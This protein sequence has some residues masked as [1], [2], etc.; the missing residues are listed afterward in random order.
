MIIRSYRLYEKNIAVLKDYGGLRSRIT[1]FK[2]LR[3]AGLEI[4]RKQKFRGQQHDHK[5]RNNISRANSK[6]FEYA[7]CNPWD[8][9]VTLTIDGSKYQRDDLGTYYK[10]FSQWL[11]D[12]KK[13]YNLDF[14]YV[15][16]PELHKDGKSWHMHGLLHGLPLEHLT[17]NDNGYLD[18]EPYRRKFGYISIDRIRDQ[19][20]TA[21]YITKYISKDLSKC[22]TECNAKMYY[23]SRGLKT[24]TEVLR[25]TLIDGIVPDFENEYL[26]LQWFDRNIDINTLKSKF[27]DNSKAES[28]KGYLIDL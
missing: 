13:K 22:I 1:V 18:W 19:A 23:C 11:R 25:G 10:A 26:K 2:A 5:L 15:L 12:Y 28:C 17:L 16:I 3:N 27:L 6:V 4:D 9:F 21:S 24:A 20:R 8:Y 14:A 7:Y